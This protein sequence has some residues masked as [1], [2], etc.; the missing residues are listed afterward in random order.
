MKRVL[1]VAYHLPPDPGIGALRPMG[2]FDHLP[3]HGW[4]PVLLAA[5]RS[6]AVRDELR[7]KGPL[8]EVDRFDI[9]RLIRNPL[10]RGILDERIRF[11][12]PI[13]TASRSN[14]TV[15]SSLKH[16]VKSVAAFPDRR[17]GWWFGAFREAKQIIRDHSIDV[18]VTTSPPWTTALVGA[19]LTSATGVPWVADMRDLWSQYHRY[20]FGKL[21]HR[22]DTWLERRTL[23]RAAAVVV[24]S[25]PR[26][27]RL[28]GLHPLKRIE[29][30]TLG[31]DP[32]HF[33]PNG[34]SPSRRVLTITHAGKLKGQDALHYFKALAELIQEGSIPA[35]RIT[36]RFWGPV[37]EEQKQIAREFGLEKTVVFY[38]LVPRAEVL[39]RELESHLLLLFTWHDPS[40]PGIHFGKL[41]D[42]LGAR[43]TILGVGDHPEVIAEVLARTRA[44]VHLTSVAA[45]KRFLLECYAEVTATGF[46]P[47]DGDS[48]EVDRYSY[49][50]IAGEFA[51]ILDSV[52]AAK[53]EA[54]R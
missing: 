32:R 10:S 35:E 28:R 3:S 19:S 43:R 39:R 12:T 8:Y 41:F 34:V 53:D 6:G 17:N 24:V 45:I 40:E 49:S 4:S 25:E 20:D 15:T 29:S 2:L 23:A 13:L 38:D 54:G 50:S 47:Y 48:Q 33:D 44:G 51:A 18:V 30:V 37:D 52:T 27:R 14:A 9:L 36:S 16:L 5:R 7:A 22:L 11:Q 26:A 31:F 1:I 46:V 21:R 42:Y